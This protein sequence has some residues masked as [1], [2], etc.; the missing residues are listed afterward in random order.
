[1]EIFKNDYGQHWT[2]QDDNQLHNLYNEDALDIMEISK[3]IGRGPGVIISRLVK[4]NY[5]ANR[6]LA[7]GY[8]AYK[9]TDLYKQSVLSSMNRNKTA[10]VCKPEKTNK[11]IQ[12]ENV[13]IGINK[14]DYIELQKDVKEMKN[15]INGLKNYLK[16]LIE[17]MNAV[18]EFENI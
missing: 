18:Y 16:E 17:M 14:S 2:S 15:E 5:I 10:P 13:L 7:R 6:T 3:L 4:L 1:M 11:P 9:N 8:T 12:I